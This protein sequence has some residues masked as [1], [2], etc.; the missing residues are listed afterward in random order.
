VFSIGACLYVL[1]LAHQISVDVIAMATWLSLSINFIIDAFGHR[2]R[3]GIPVRSPITHS[4]FTAPFWGGLV[5]A[6]SIFVV[7]EA[8][9]FV[10][11][12]EI[13]VFW[14]TVGALVAM[15]HLFLDG[16]TQ[17]G[18]YWTR[19]RIALAHFRYNNIPLNLGFT[20]I[21][22]I[23]IGASLVRPGLV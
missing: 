22:V 18:V 2:S 15:S 5:A 8:L 16:L 1:S 9:T 21:G 20:A 14:T 7:F 23:L 10:P 6:L 4:V 12:W 17:A 11:G 19:R 13:L 3:N